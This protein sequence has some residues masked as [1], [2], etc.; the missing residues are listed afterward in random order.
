MTYDLPSFSLYLSHPLPGRKENTHT[1]L[2]M[3]AHVPALQKQ[4]EGT[5]VQDQPGPK[6]QVPNHA[7]APGGFKGLDLSLRTAK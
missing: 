2:D 3:V 7:E 6:Q 1:K 5:R 4:R